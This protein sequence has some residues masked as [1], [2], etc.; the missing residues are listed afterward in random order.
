MSYVCLWSPTWPTAADFPA[1]LVAALLAHAPRVA[2]G[3][4]HGGAALVWADARGLHAGNLA[5][6]LVAVASE[7]GWDDVHAGAATTPVAAE[8]AATCGTPP[9]VIVKPGTDRQFIAPHPFRVLSPSDQLTSLLDGLGIVTCGALAALDAEQIEVRLGLDG[10]RLWEKARAGDERWLFRIP[11]RALPSASIEWVEYG[12]RDPERLLF[13]INSLAGTVCGALVESGVRAREM[14]LVFFLGTRNQRT[15]VVRSSR[16]SAEQKRWTRLMREALD[17]ITLP[18]AV[19][20]L[21]LRVESVTGNDGAQGDLFD[22]GFATQGAVDDALL[23]LTD[24]QGDVVVE[25]LNSAHPLIDERTTW[26]PVNGEA[27]GD[28]APPRGASS[29]AVREKRTTQAVR[30]TPRAATAEVQAALRLQLLPMARSVT[31]E[32]QPRRDHDVPV[33][34]DDGDGSYDL[35]EAAG[36]DRVSGGKWSVNGPY[37]REYF[38]C[39][40]E[41]GTMVWLYRTRG[42]SA[43]YLQGW[44]D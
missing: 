37:A 19:T 42:E 44:W 26:T 32:T 8:V 36:P 35:I 3:D 12:L 23:Q 21:A 10:V 15:H 29:H 1:D 6:Q 24:D 5:E 13:I 22:R 16:P 20:G 38:R 17:A 25:P 31:V 41:D 18:E 9:L 28:A 33:R 14:A 34:Y 2:V 11:P 7:H 43:W 4:A 39:V 40:R 30:E 27:R